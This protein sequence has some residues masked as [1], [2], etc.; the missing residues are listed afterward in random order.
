MC[1]VLVVYYS[2][3]ILNVVLFLQLKSLFVLFKSCFSFF[4]PFFVNPSYTALFLL[5]NIKT[6]Y[7]A[8][9]KRVSFTHKNSLGNKTF[10][11]PKLFL[12]INYVVL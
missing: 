7:N 11:F 3:Y 5:I 6:T 4:V 1:C 9:T 12:V 8:R 10:A 2:L